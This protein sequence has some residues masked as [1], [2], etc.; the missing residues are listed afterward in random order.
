M[1][2]D[3]LLFATSTSAAAIA[4]GMFNNT[5]VDFRQM[6]YAGAIA[7][8]GVVAGNLLLSK[9]NSSPTS[10]QS[11]FY[12]LGGGFL[13]AFAMSQDLGN[14]LITGVAGGYFG[15]QLLKMIVLYRVENYKF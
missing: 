9:I 15:P 10:T 1:E 5:S 3:L 11:T 14:S 8:A 12:R 6:L 2:G 7:G 13:S 4:D